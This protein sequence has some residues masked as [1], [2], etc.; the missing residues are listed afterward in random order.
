MPQFLV[1]WKARYLTFTYKVT[2][3][4]SYGSVNGV[5]CFIN[6]QYMT[7]LDGGT[8]AA[9]YESDDA[10]YEELITWPLNI[11]AKQANDGATQLTGYYSQEAFTYRMVS[12]NEKESVN[13]ILIALQ[14]IDDISFECITLEIQGAFEAVQ[15]EFDSLLSDIV[16][17]E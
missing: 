6:D 15:P 5:D 8:I 16:S 12:Y 7:Y 4:S 14:K 17:G 3:Y 11:Y 1:L 2:E 9:H 13:T 10:L